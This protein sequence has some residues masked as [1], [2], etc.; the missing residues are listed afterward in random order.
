MSRKI[1]KKQKEFADSYVETGNG[2]QSALKVYD[3]KSPIVAGSIA[4]ENLTKPNVI[5]YLQGIS[6][7][8]ANHVEQLAFKAE[9]EN[10]QMLASKDILDRSGYKPTDKMQITGN[11]T[12][13]SVFKKSK[14]VKQI[15]DQKPLE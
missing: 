12:L 1:T 3:T 5:E 10:V 15:E 14:E 13:E 8:V 11:F 7:R 6:Y 4:T 9:S 2:R